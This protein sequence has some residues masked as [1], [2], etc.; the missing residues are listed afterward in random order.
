MCELLLAKG[1]CVVALDISQEG[2]RS[3]EAWATAISVQTRLTCVACDV[4]SAASVDKAVKAVGEWCASVVSE[5]GGVHSIVHTAGIF[6]CG[7]LVEQLTAADISAAL[8]VNVMGVV[9]V[10][11]AFFSAMRH[12]DCGALPRIL[13]VASE[14]SAARMSVALT[15][16]Y[17]MSKF[18]VEAYAIALRQ[19]LAVLSPPTHVCVVRPGPVHTPLTDEATARRARAHAE[20]SPR[21]RANLMELVDTAAQ[22]SR[23]RG[24]APAAA[25]SPMYDACHAVTPPRHLH[26]NY[27]LEMRLAACMP[28]WVLDATIS[29]KMRRAQRRFAEG[30]S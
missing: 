1:D 23:L 29:Q 5:Y 11:R 3:L 26:I 20:L 2:L 12:D 25:A 21:W 16:P 24:I 8:A 10:T 30:A 18:C 28:Q 4:S 15:A 6:A 14:L 27:T 13:L 19:E 7:P 22:Y 17:A 9:H